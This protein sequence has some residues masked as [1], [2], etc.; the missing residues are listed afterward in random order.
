M[1]CVE[2]KKNTKNKNAKPSQLN[3]TQSPKLTRKN[4]IR[5]L[6]A[7]ICVVI[8]ATICG[9][10]IAVCGGK[11][12]SNWMKTISRYI[13]I[14]VGAIL[15]TQIKKWSKKQTLSGVL[16]IML[17]S[18]F[19]WTVIVIGSGNLVIFATSSL[20]VEYWRNNIDSEKESIPDQ[21]EENENSVKTEPH[22]N[23][24]K[25]LWNEDVFIKD[26]SK[27]YDFI[28]GNEEEFKLQLIF[29]FL[30]DEMREY[31]RENFEKYKELVN[32]ASEYYGYYEYGEKSNYSLDSQHMELLT[33]YESRMEA[34]KYYKTSLNLRLIGQAEVDLGAIEKQMNI[35]GWQVRYSD[36]L[37]HYILALK[38]A[39]QENNRKE[40]S[41][42]WDRIIKEYREISEFDSWDETIVFY[43]KDMWNLCQENG[44]EIKKEIF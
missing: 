10:V 19:I 1:S 33:S 5:R 13:L 32:M 23:N 35:D 2:K 44:A 29:E 38:Y 20:R 24:K 41:I 8:F 43:A 25:F 15:V 31:E 27:Y 26:V 40:S 12:I 37:E 6:N 7:L 18:F 36:A 14:A 4:Y 16:R 9:F 11:V 3:C 17:R 21:T 30:S 34:N 39:I 42:I 22:R 28:S